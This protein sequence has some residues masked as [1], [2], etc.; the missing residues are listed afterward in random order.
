MVWELGCPMLSTTFL[1]S[2]N[3]KILGTSAHQI[4]SL[5]TILAWHPDKAFLD[6]RI[7]LEPFLGWFSSHA[8]QHPISSDCNLYIGETST[9]LSKYKV[10]AAQKISQCVIN[11]R[12]TISQLTMWSRRCYTSD[13]RETSQPQPDSEKSHLNNNDKTIESRTS[14]Q[15]D[16]MPVQNLKLQLRSSTTDLRLSPTTRERIGVP[17][18]EEYQKM[19]SGV[20]WVMAHISIV[21]ETEV[22]T[23]CLS[24]SE[25]FLAPC[26]R[27][28]NLR[29]DVFVPDI[30]LMTKSSEMICYPCPNSSWSCARSGSACY[31]RS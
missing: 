15:T 30:T 23:V 8:Y 2:E 4:Y 10:Y 6:S 31:V 18:C 21:S 3:S 25:S 19:I 27:P 20:T 9:F 12:Q 5:F 29:H 22:L 1:F 13:H 7:L 16:V 28:R 14:S 26:F 24:V 17:D 11:M